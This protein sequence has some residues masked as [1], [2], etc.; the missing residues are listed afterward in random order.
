MQAEIEPS[1][2]DFENL[3]TVL[4]VPEMAKVLRIGRGSA[5]ELVRS[6]GVPSVKVGK[7]VRIPR[8]GLILWM[9]KGNQS[10]EEVA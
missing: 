9:S 4:T 2:I 5:Y 1:G 7:L 6:G 10:T 3:P 8:D